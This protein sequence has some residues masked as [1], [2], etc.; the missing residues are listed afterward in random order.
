LMDGQFEPLQGRMPTGV[1][2]Q[3]TSADVHVGLIERYI[4]TTKERTLVSL[5]LLV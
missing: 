2:L 3:V 5:L 1:Q 4:R